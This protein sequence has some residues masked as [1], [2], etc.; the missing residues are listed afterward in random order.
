[1]NGYFIE[2]TCELFGNFCDFLFGVELDIVLFEEEH[3]LIE[4]EFLLLIAVHYVEQQ[5]PKL[6]LGTT[7]SISLHLLRFGILINIQSLII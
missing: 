1:M 6:F 7:A 4:V 3:E 2:S 5:L